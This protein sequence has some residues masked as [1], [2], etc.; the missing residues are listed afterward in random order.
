MDVLIPLLRPDA[1]KT[2]Q[3][4]ACIALRCSLQDYLS[5]KKNLGREFMSWLRGN[6]SD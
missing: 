1:E 3:D 6:K 2:G 5:F 4:A